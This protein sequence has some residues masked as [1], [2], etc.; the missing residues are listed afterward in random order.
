[1]INKKEN[2]LKD[3]SYAFSLRIIKAYKFLNKK[4]CE[5]A[6]SNQLIRNGTAIGALIREAEYAQSIADFINKMSVALKETN[7]TEYWLTLL[8]DSGYITDNMFNSIVEDCREILKL[9]ISSIKTAKS[10]SRKT[11]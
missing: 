11:K 9:L 8:K 7:E 10:K 5:F 6:L 1:M 2:I 4:N 3:K